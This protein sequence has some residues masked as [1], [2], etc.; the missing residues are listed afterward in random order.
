MAGALPLC[1]SLSCRGRCR[2]SDGLRSQ[3]P[4]ALVN[5]AAVF[6]VHLRSAGDVATQP[7]AE[8][9]GSGL[10]RLIILLLAAPAKKILGGAHSLFEALGGTGTHILNK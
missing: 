10:T 2:L 8:I 3:R 5:L 6:A 7:S 9:M 1:S 4:L